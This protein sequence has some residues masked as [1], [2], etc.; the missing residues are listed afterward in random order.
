MISGKWHKFP[1]TWR[2]SDLGTGRSGYRNIYVL[3]I[4][5][6]QWSFLKIRIVKGLNL[7]VEYPPSRL[8][9]GGFDSF[10]LPAGPMGY[11][12]SKESYFFLHDDREGGR[13]RHSRNAGCLI[14]YTPTTSLLFGF[15]RQIRR[16]RYALR[17]LLS[18]KAS[19]DSGDGTM[20]LTNCLRVTPGPVPHLR[21]FWILPPVF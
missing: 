8:Y 10:N 4:L 1:L 5:F 13:R 9:F 15:D 17:V 6:I 7:R 11:T 2:I 18:Q 19:E 12:C 21:L 14:T 20:L 16:G 3:I